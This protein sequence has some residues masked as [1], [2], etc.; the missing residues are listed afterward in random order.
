MAPGLQGL[1]L[2][3]AAATGDGPVLDDGAAHG[4][5]SF[6]MEITGAPTRVAVTIS[7]IINTSQT[8]GVLAVL[9]TAQG[10]IAGQIV[11]LTFP[12]SVRK[13]KA[14]LDTLTGGTSPTVTL[15]Y[16]AR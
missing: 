15:H 14:H 7:G 9:D 1:L 10:Y 6:Q 13:I 2:N 8:W 16:A 3:A 11:S 4:F 12:V 5:G